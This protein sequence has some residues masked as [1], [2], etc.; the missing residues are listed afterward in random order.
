MKKSGAGYAGAI[1][2][3]VHRPSYAWRLRS[4]GMAPSP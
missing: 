1:T 4:A 3:G 2:M